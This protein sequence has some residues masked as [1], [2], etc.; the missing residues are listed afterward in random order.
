MANHTKKYK[1]VKDKLRTTGYGKGGGDEHEDKETESEA[2]L[3]PRNVSKFS[4]YG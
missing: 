2:E 4:R 3:I 1:T